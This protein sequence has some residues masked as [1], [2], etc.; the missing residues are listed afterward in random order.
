MAAVSIAFDAPDNSGGAAPMVSR[1][2]DLDHLARQTMGDKTL[3]I[4]VLQLF[5]RSTRHLLQE[6][7][8]SDADGVKALAHRLKGAADAIG[9][10]RVSA[11]AATLEND[12][13]DSAA[14]ARVSVAVVEAENFILKLCR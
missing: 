3:E 8:A 2:I 10:V 6:L 13:R 1:P 11:A 5:A 12:G 9:A 4:E 14:I 7:S